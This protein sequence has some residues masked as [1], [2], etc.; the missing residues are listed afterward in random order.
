MRD[1]YMVEQ[2]AEGYL[3]SAF[4]NLVMFEFPINPGTIDGPDNEHITIGVA[5]VGRCPKCKGILYFERHMTYS[6][7]HDFSPKQLEKEVLERVSDDPR[8]IPIHQS[9]DKECGPVSGCTC[10]E[11]L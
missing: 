11:E 3:R 7:D 9:L 6:L 2:R 4:P 8:I 10:E 1:Y 5:Q